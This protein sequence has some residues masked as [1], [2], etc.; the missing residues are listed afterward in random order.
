MGS[1]GFVLRFNRYFN[2]SF[3][4]LVFVMNNSRWTDKE[5]E[6]ALS[7]WRNKYTFSK[8]ALAIGKTRNAVIG[9]INRENPDLKRSRLKTKHLEKKIPGQGKKHFNNFKNGECL[10]MS[11]NDGIICANP[12]NKGA[13]CEKCYDL[14]H[15]KIQQKSVRYEV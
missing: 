1:C 8:I 10:Y 9:K 15:H 14:C 13:Y 6:T 4:G 7:M 11:G 12:V 5:Y 2:R 3:T